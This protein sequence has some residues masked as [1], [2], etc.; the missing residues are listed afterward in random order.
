MNRPTLTKRQVSIITIILAAVQMVLI[1]YFGGIRPASTQREKL[2]ALKQNVADAHAI[3][4]QEAAIRRNLAQSLADMEP[5]A[6]YAPVLPD[7]YAWA[8]EYVSRCAAQS[9]V[10][11]DNLEE[12]AP[13]PDDQTKS[14]GQPYG[15]RIFTHCGYNNLDEFLW[16]LEKDNPLLRIKQVT[17]AMVPGLAQEPRVQIDVQWWTAL[18]SVH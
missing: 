9:Q 17:I 2:T 15:I 12:T 8:Y 16:R 7:R 5:L 6:E 11:L 4:Q 14:A 18:K 1:A 10:K 3:I 13:Q